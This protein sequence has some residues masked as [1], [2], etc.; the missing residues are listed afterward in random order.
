MNVVDSR[1]NTTE[2]AAAQRRGKPRAQAAMFTS[3]SDWRSKNSWRQ[4]SQDR[5]FGGL[6]E[7]RHAALEISKVS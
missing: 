3:I 6:P 2:Q 7:T 5:P 1:A 4:Q